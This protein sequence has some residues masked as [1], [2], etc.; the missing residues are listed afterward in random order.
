MSSN[1]ELLRLKQKSYLLG[2]GTFLFDAS[3]YA[4]AIAGTI[5]APHLR[6]RIACGVIAG[7]WTSGLII[8]GHDA[9]HQS[10]TPSRRLNRLLGTLAFLPA[11][12]VYS[13][14]KYGHNHLHHLFTNRRGHDYV[15]EPLSLGEFQSLPWWSRTR[16][17][18]FR[19]PLGH[20][21]YYP[22]EIWWKRRFI[23]Q[24]RYVGAIRFRYWFDFLIVVG[25]LVTLSLASVWLRSRISGQP[26]SGFADWA[27]PLALTV[28]L[29]FVVSGMLMS[30]T[31]FL[32][33]THPRIHWYTEP[34]A[35]DWID[36]QASTA[37]HCRFPGIMDWLM[38]WIMDHTAHH[39]QPAIPSYRLLE[40]QRSVETERHETV[41]TY[42]WSP[43]TVLQ[44]LR[45]CKL[46]DNGA[47]CWT[48][49]TGQPT[50]D[51]RRLQS[52][53]NHGR[54]LPMGDISQAKAA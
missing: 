46:Y 37:V 41:V 18:F 3:C 19:T 40:A 38:H 45:V 2:L 53:A 47:G 31:E 30:A 36:R 10:L 28:L 26:V 7:F 20:L 50:S 12:H 13:L 34:T 16:Y 22:S 52:A 21:F 33:H 39:M 11:L 44:I 14:W 25:W 1:A 43:R 29:P 6:H 4:L 48:D 54:K 5:A 35:G 9:C 15:W 42:R 49:Y 27:G 24:Q 23:P 17:R 8:V 51:S 32:Q